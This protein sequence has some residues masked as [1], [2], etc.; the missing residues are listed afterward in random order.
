ME[1]MFSIV[2]KIT[3][4]TQG[5]AIESQSCVKHKARHNPHKFFLKKTVH[6]QIE[7]VS[8]VIRNENESLPPL[9]IGEE[10]GRRKNS[11]TKMIHITSMNK[12][13]LS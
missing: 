9:S 13:Q 10:Q 3:H 12:R 5:I 6:V 8:Y 7:R 2:I 1:G 4:N 11:F